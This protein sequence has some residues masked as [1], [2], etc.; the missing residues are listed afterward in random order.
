MVLV[1][2]HFIEGEINSGDFIIENILEDKFLTQDNSKEN[3]NSKSSNENE[4]DITKVR[5]S[6][7][8]IIIRNAI[9][10][11]I[12]ILTISLF[13]VIGVLLSK[14]FIILIIIIGMMLFT[15]IKVFKLVQKETNCKNSH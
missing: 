9:L 5:E 4:L 11:L 15:L 3:Q 7:S 8:G 2:E 13:S 12:S 6:L 14:L 1:K 10:L